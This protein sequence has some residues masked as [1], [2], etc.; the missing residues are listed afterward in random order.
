MKST[1]VVLFVP[2]SL[3]LGE[4][5][6]DGEYVRIMDRFT[7]RPP[8]LRLCEDLI[9]GI[10]PRLD[11]KVKVKVNGSK[12]NGTKWAFGARDNCLP[13]FVLEI[14]LLLS[15][16]PADLPH[17]ARRP[18]LPDAHRSPGVRESGRA[19]GATHTVH[20]TGS[21]AGLGGMVARTVALVALPAARC[22]TGA[23]T[24]AR[25]P[26]QAVARRA[27]ERARN[28]E[29]NARTWKGALGRDMAG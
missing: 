8:T 29:G 22:P 3:V 18:P 16:P 12:R 10:F 21:G 11:V 26:A 25:A 6:Y 17:G 23:R 24:T 27:R 14:L 28:N 5:N 4:T 20:R 7:G 19:A 9:V 2:G 1:I 13:C 15:E